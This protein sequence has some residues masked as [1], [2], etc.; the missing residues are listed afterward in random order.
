MA[1][2]QLE[3]IARQLAK[4]PG[5][6]LA[7]DESNPTIGKRF[8]E[9]GLENSPESRRD[10]REMLLTSP[11]LGKY[12]NG[13]ILFTE[14]LEQKTSDGGTFVEVLN[15]QGIIPGVKVDLGLVDMPNYPGE[16][17]TKGIDGLRERLQ[18]YIEKGAKFAKWR[19]V[20]SIGGEK[21]SEANIQANAQGLALYAAFC[22]EQ[23][24]V[25][26]VEPE[27]LMDGNHSILD[28]YA[29]TGKALKALFENIKMFRVSPKAL[30]LKPNMVVQGKNYLGKDTSA[31]VVAN[32]TFTVL[33]KEVPREVALIAFLSGGLKDEAAAE[34]LSTINR[35]WYG[36]TPWPL[37]FSFARALQ[38]VPM[39]EYSKG[40]QESYTR[41]QEILVETARKMSLATV[42]KYQP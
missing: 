9:V 35:K 32:A 31:E 12:I 40:T 38:T 26:I 33:S 6:I 14:T 41:A 4:K 22:Q 25:P 10:Y 37:S 2:E 18:E 34:Y 3:E 15:E 17:I 28:C 30:V 16:K 36:A 20:Y 24:L 39:K 8:S 21:P 11:D 13:V 42:G 23:G 5:G 19:A 7:A 27:V 1:H 29:A